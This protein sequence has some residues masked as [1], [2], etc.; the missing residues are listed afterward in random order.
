LL[1]LSNNENLVEGDMTTEQTASMEDYLETIAMLTEEKGIA[2]V[3]QL[4]RR[5][6]VKMPS[7]T[8]ALR[9]LSEQG[10]VEH[11]RYGYVRLTPEGNKIAADVWRRH[12]VLS[13]FLAEILGIAPDTA[14]EDA[15]KMEHSVSPASLERLAKFVEFVLSCPRSEPVWLKGF[16]YYFKHGERSEELIRK[17][18]SGDE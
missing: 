15:C 2:R 10:L 7:V 13:C 18:L 14:Q 11:E 9:K 6:G 1:E 5:L 4:G 17:C 8:A 12:K 16:D 3:S